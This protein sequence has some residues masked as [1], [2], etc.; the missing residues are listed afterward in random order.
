MEQLEERVSSL[1]EALKVVIELQRRNEILI[2]K[3][4]DE[5]KEFK[6]EMRAFKDEMYNFK[7][8]S[9]KAWGDMARKL[10][11]I[12]EDVIYPAFRPVIEQYFKCKVDTSFIR[13]KAKDKDLSDEFDVVGISDGCKKIFLV[14]VKSN[15]TSKDVLDFLNKKID[16]FR[17]ELKKLQVKDYEIVP[18]FASLV[19]DDSVVN[20][21]TKNK[22]YA[23][24]YREWEYM[25]ILNFNEITKKQ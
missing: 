3:L 4:A 21:L 7:K 1:E 10:G 9:N 17:L 20:L 6:D 8:E 23:M 18:I 11:T 19:F 24:A 5:M 15:P 25:D 14:E 12:V 16:S 13:F 2:E 22:I